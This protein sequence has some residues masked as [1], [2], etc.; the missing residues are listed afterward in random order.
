MATQLSQATHLV[1]P[2]LIRT[3]KL[4]NAITLGL[5]IVPEKWIR[6][7]QTEKKF[8]SEASYRFENVAE[9]NQQYNCDFYKTLE[10]KNRNKI[11]SNK[12]FFITPSVF[13]SCKEIRCLIE[14]GGGI[15]ENKRRSL[16]HI[17][18]VNA[19][20]PCTYF[21]ITTENDLHLVYDCLRNSNQRY[22]SSCEIV[23]NS[24]LTQEFNPEEFLVRVHQNNSGT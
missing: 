10:C 14:S 9:F 3:L 13:P 5:T 11:F 16:Q 4:M 19:N 7:C 22:V 6:D 24:I 18:A 15:V 12:S 23:F 21:I 8:I 2:N 17:D 20:V 1:M